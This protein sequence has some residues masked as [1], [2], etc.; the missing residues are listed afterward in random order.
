MCPSWNGVAEEIEALASDRLLAAHVEPDP[1]ERRLLACEAQLLHL[2]C[3]AALGRP[4]DAWM[5]HSACEGVVVHCE[6]FVM[7]GVS[8]QAEESLR[9]MAA[10]GLSGDDPP[11][12]TAVRADGLE[13]LRVL[14]GVP[15][16]PADDNPPDGPPGSPRPRHPAREHIAAVAVALTGLTAII[17]GASPA[18]FSL[19]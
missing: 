10:D 2:A 5:V 12:A 8:R 19:L 4:T 11:G 15:L 13:V 9:V 7:W 14:L 17:A 18:A 6:M 1:D 3:D 16:Q